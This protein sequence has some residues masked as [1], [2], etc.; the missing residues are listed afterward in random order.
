M[1][2]KSD[3]TAAHSTL[4]HTL[5]PSFILTGLLLA[6]VSSGCVRDTAPSEVKTLPNPP[7]V[8]QAAQIDAGS[9]DTGE[10]EQG[11]LSVPKLEY[12]DRSAL[13][14]AQFLVAERSL[15]QGLSTLDQ[16]RGSLGSYPLFPYL[17][18][19]T[20]IKQ[21]L[22]EA[23]VQAFLQAYPNSPLERR[24]RNQW[25][26]QL[27]RAENW[28]AFVQYYPADTD[29]E[30]LQCQYLWARWQLKPDAALAKEVSQFW[31]IGKSRHAG[32]QP[33]FDAWRQAGHQTETLTW[34]RTR[35]ALLA[36]ND[37]LASS[38]A[39]SLSPEHQ[40]LLTQ[41]RQWQK[42]PKADDSYR[43][44]ASP[45]GTELLTEA[46]LV[47][48]KK[49]PQQ[50]DERY[51]QLQAQHRFT[52]EQQQRLQAGINLFLAVGYDPRASDRIDAMDPAAIGPDLSFWYLRQQLRNQDWPRLIQSYSHQPA[53]QRQEEIWRYWYARA[54]EQQN[55]KPAAEQ[56]YRTLARER[57]YYG[58]LAAARL[59]LKP[60]LNHKGLSLTDAQRNR[61]L[62]L[63]GLLRAFELKQLGRIEDARREWRASA[64]TLPKAERPLIAIPAHHWGWHPQ[65][66]S[67]LAAEK[68]FDDIALRFPT[69]YR[70]QVLQ[71]SQQKNLSPG[72][73]FALMRQE[74]SFN[75]SARSPAKALGLM[76]VLPSTAAHMGDTSGGSDLLKPDLNIGYGTQYMRLMFDKF[77]HFSA[78][79]AAYNAG[80]S[81]VARWWP[82]QPMPTDLWVE[83]IPY[84]ET[85]HY[86]QNLTTYRILYNRLLEQDPEFYQQ[87]AQDQIGN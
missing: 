15:A 83:Q 20:L 51:Q 84:K 1:A 9:R 26:T 63:P 41:W 61:L 13:D 2:K 30:L 62:N 11:P 38:L 48:A 82:S 16:W 77:G 24:L 66:I 29:S 53:S 21:P 80:P 46:L 86:V 65:V 47:L 50:A 71:N 79:T 78:T 85:R 27:A 69:P 7:S 75:A 43:F 45:E 23:E 60:Q 52:P 44:N 59:G 42:N 70:N 18:Y 67:F 32:C 5:R 12:S 37:G 8:Q 34:A 49:Q 6:L 87:L 35:L 25:L 55:Q 22:Q 74:S 58:F 57:S 10:P 72:W 31:L 33:L 36:G 40:Q 76:Q 73:V 64:N 19:Q 39:K 54:L 4:S 68:Y 81:P 28:S 14:R 3:F 56:L 17:E